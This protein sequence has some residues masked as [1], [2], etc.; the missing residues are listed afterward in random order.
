MR[1][2]IGAT[3]VL[4]LAVLVLLGC[5]TPQPVLDTA[6]RLGPADL[7][8][9]HESD[10]AAPQR[11]GPVKLLIYSSQ[12]EKGF[13]FLYENNDPVLGSKHEGE[14][15]DERDEFDLA[16][17]DTP[18]FDEF[19]RR[20]QQKRIATAV[21]RENVRGPVTRERLRKLAEQDRTDFVFVF[22]REV[23]FASSA[24]FPGFIWFPIGFALSFFKDTDKV[25]IMIRSEG[26]LYDRKYDR[27]CFL[28][29]APLQE[30]LASTVWSATAGSGKRKIRD[31]A[32]DGLAQLLS[33]AESVLTGLVQL[34]PSSRA[35]S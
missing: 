26:L 27:V 22:R 31:M 18:L 23:Q 19:S 12:P 10:P 29:T 28:K 5:S 33:Q 15:D 11:Q 34:L 4:V 16:G 2:F 21:P 8:V 1:R 20:L 17:I 14:V 25:A 30:E 6:R 9:T 32:R 24:R 35:P 3:L 13:T 7:F